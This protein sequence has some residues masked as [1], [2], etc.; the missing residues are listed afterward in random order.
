MH[1]VRIITGGGTLIALLLSVA[2]A[3]APSPVTPKTSRESVRSN[4]KE[5]NNGSYS[6]AIS[7]DG[8]FVA[9]DSDASNLAGRDG[10]HSSDV[11]LRNRVGE[12]TIRVTRGNDGSFDPSVS[13]DGRFVVFD[14]DATNLIADDLNSSTDIFIFDRTNRDIS[15]ASL[16]ADHRRT[17]FD[18]Y[19]PAISA[20]GRAIVFSSYATD[21]VSGDTNGKSDIFVR[22]RRRRLT[23]RVSVR[24]NGA[25]ANGPSISPDVSAKGRFVV[26]ESLASNL[27][28]GDSNETY[29]VF[30]R[31]RDEDKT[32]RLSVSSSGKQARKPS[33]E[34][35]V[36]AD[37]SVV[38]FWSSASTLVHG[39]TNHRED[40]FVRDRIQGVTERISVKSNGGQTRRGSFAPAVSADGRFVAFWSFAN[41]LVSNDTNGEPDVFVHDRVTGTTK[42]VSVGRGG[43]P[44]RDGSFRP[45]LSADGGLVAFHSYA[46]NLVAG[47]TNGAS[48]VFVRGTGL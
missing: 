4:G 3:S 45:V 10:N 20:D 28:G 32:R 41:N 42:L 27:V 9:F 15:V 7:A 18:S 34:P 37:G 46:K 26:F 13:G 30:I 31:D 25:Q 40:I 17:N 19:E 33:H 11:F 43:G 23:R 14:S 38:A 44:A 5:A 6:S 1:R 39:D 29:D 24:S 48:D 47:D 16:G 36:S 12:R 21:V 35:A 8:T 22:L 2:A